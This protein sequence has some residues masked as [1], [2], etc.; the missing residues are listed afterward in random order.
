MDDLSEAVT[1]SNAHELL[2]QEFER[3][4]PEGLLQEKEALQF[5][6]VLVSQLEGELSELKYE[7]LYQALLNKKMDLSDIPQS[8]RIRDFKE[9]RSLYFI[10]AHRY[11][12]EQKDVSYAIVLFTLLLADIEEAVRLGQV[13]R[14]THY[15]LM[16]EWFH[17]L[18]Y[19]KMEFEGDGEFERFFQRQKEQRRPLFEAFGY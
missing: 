4:Y 2:K 17:Y 10:A 15:R 13:N 7:V 16:R 11:A 14:E 12:R 3:L 1:C 8:L 19:D 18:V 6:Q 5:Y 9:G